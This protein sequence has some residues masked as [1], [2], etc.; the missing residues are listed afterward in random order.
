MIHVLIDFTSYIMFCLF[1]VTVQNTLQTQHWSK[2][3]TMQTVNI[4]ILLVQF[5]IIQRKLIF[6]RRHFCTIE[7]LNLNQIAFTLNVR[8]KNIG[9]V[10]TKII[11]AKLSSLVRTTI[12]FLFLIQTSP[13]MIWC[14]K[15]VKETSTM[16]MKEYLQTQNGKIYFISMFVNIHNCFEYEVNTTTVQNKHF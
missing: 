14:T 9:K 2:T 5:Y 1:K 13:A 12:H 7:Y 3:S 8:T 10:L 15:T 6:V 11:K 16:L 4:I